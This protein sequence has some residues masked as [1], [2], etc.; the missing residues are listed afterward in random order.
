ML[1][2]S[3][4]PRDCEAAVPTAVAVD[5]EPK[6]PCATVRVGRRERARVGLVR[7]GAA[8]TARR[9]RCRVRVLAPEQANLAVEGVGRL[10]NADFAAGRQH[11]EEL[12]RV[13]ASATATRKGAVASAG[14][15]REG[16]GD[17][18]ITKAERAGQQTAAV[19]SIVITLTVVTVLM[20]VQTW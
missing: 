9:V 14:R 2:S 4:C 15:G 11:D 5:H 10:S 18:R 17:A 19:F 7:A 3:D 16:A 1:G 12:V 20:I 8:A 13:T 6:L